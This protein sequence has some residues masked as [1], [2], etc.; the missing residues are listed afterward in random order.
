MGRVRWGVFVWA[1]VSALVLAW[2]WRGAIAPASAVAEPG[3]PMPAAGRPA[4]R[5]PVPSAEP[6]PVDPARFGRWLDERS[7]LRGTELDGSWDVDGQ[8]RFLPTLALRRRFDQLLTLVG[9]TPVERITAF[10]E[11][12]VRELAGGYAAGAVLD[13]WQR[14]LELQRHAWRT[15]ARPGDRQALAAALAERQQVRLRILGP[16]LAQAFFA[17]DAAQLQALMRGEPV[18]PEGPTTQIDTARLD[19]LALARLQAE[20]AAWAA[21]Q[22]RLEAARREVQ[23]LQAAPELSALQRTQAIERLLAQRFDAQ[24]ALRVRALLHLPPP[25]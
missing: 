20:D 9:E 25:S 15:Q 22:R 7:S 19:A 1:G 18:A 2:G 12:D 24:E 11:H 6:T 14:Y 10:V 21:W 3:L 13:A 17:D 23:A 16:E 8:G 4:M 5:Q